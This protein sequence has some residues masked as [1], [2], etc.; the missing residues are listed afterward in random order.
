[1]MSK[2]GMFFAVFLTLA[3][4][5]P[6]AKVAVINMQSAILGTTEGRQASEA[7]Q[8]KFQPRADQIEKQRR[9]VAS[10][11]TELKLTDA[12][13]AELAERRRAISREEQNLHA[14][15]SNEQKRVLNELVKRVMPT[16]ESYAKRKHFSMV[17]DIS[18]SE[19][20]VVWFAHST[21]ITK[22]VVARYER[23]AGHK[24]R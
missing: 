5:A 9:E 21:D 16:V 11:E 7:M 6:A 13:R 4:A 12:V 19:T 2:P 3:P 10:L 1:M 14:D 20:P 23:E 17:V 22:E 24:K 18:S 15:V 8:A